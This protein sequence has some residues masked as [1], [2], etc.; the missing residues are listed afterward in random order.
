M[1]VF[2]QFV[3]SFFRK[4]GLA[5]IAYRAVLRREPT[6]AELARKELGTL[7]P[8]GKFD[9]LRDMV[10]SGEFRT[11]IL[12]SLV[13]TSTKFNSNRPVFFLHIPKTG[14]TSV[15]LALSEA[16]GIPSINV[17][18]AWPKP[19]R[20][21]H[22]YWPLWAGHAQIS[23]FP[24]S[25][26]G[27]T[28]FREPRSRILSRYR[29]QQFLREVGRKHGWNYPREELLE[30]SDLDFESW[31]HSGGVHSFQWFIPHP[32]RNRRK[33]SPAEI[34]KLATEPKAILENQLRDSL[35]RFTSAA[36]LHEEQSVL[37]AIQAVAGCAPDRL[38]VEN[39]ATGKGHDF[40]FLDV[41]EKALSRI[42]WAAR[43]D[44]LVI[45]TAAELGL[46]PELS[47]EES[48]RQ[49]RQTAAKLKFNLP[50]E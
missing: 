18:N 25:H 16:L 49:F 10:E 32:K 8:G 43:F 48:D 9:L 30:K 23:F 20:D 34:T 36:W 11:Q 12:P 14:G 26:E 21:S 7:G 2:W 39:T 50:A 31:V 47:S 40:S 42:N 17:Y 45:R 27:F 24:D 41:S 46:I 5:L 4:K 13:V 38:P 15:R 44:E 37:N 35:R 19:D 33:W 28:V 3:G 22:A 1:T 6:S 29:Q